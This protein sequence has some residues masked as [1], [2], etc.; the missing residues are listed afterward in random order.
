V[1]GIVASKEEADAER[2]QA[3]ILSVALFEVAHSL[4]Q[5]LYGHILVV[6]R[7]VSLCG[8]PTVIDEG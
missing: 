3:A 8:V 1:D 5:L 7:K 2:S 4:H 6:L